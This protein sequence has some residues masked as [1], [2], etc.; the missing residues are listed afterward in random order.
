M[1][2]MTVHNKG[3]NENNLKNSWNTKKHPMAVSSGGE[4]Q[5]F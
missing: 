1:E 5:L 3:A 4:N 2:S